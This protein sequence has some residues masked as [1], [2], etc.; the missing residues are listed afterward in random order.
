MLVEKIL[1]KLLVLEIVLK[2]FYDRLQAHDPQL[3][4]HLAI[5]QNIKPQ[6]YAFRWILL[7][8]SQEFSLPDLITLWDAILST[9]DRLDSIQYMCLAMLDFIRDD[10]F[11]GDFST[12]V[13]LLQVKDPLF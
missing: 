6:F 13:R 5:T 9:H 12:N 1:Y 3:Y 11:K 8:L 7:L 10:L 2:H 4:N